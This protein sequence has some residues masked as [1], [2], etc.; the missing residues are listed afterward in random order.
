MAKTLTELANFYSSDKGTTFKEAHGY[1]HVYEQLLG[2]LRDEAIHLLEI[3][4]RYDPYFENRDDYSSSPS[5]QMW[6][7]YF[8]RA[9]IYGVDIHDFSALSSDRV[10]IFQGD[11]GDPAFLTGLADELPPL[12]A[13]IDDGSHASFHQQTSFKHLIHCVKPEGIYFIEDLHFQPPAL[14]AQLPKVAKTIDVLR[15][16]VTKACFDVSLFNDDKLAAMRW[17]PGWL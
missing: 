8:P 7:D 1:T 4:L 12:D 3:G 16:P 17:L 2:R 6:L 10:K 13:I 15:S 5:V 9:T 11:Q 14:E